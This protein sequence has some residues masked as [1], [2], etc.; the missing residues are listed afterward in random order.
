MAALNNHYAIIHLG[1]RNH[2]C[3]ICG[4]TYAYRKH[5]LRH[6]KESHVQEY[7]QMIDTGEIVVR[8]K[9]QLLPITLDEPAMI[10]GN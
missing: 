6:V 9:E 7:Q 3:Q 1:Q 4:R 2:I 10:L 5:M 8:M